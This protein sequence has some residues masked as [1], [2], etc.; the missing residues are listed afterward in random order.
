MIPECNGDLVTFI[1][2]IAAKCQNNW[3]YLCGCAGLLN[4]NK[5]HA[6]IFCKSVNSA[7]VELMC[8]QITYKL[9]IYIYLLYFFIAGNIPIDLLP[10][11]KIKP[12]NTRTHTHPALILLFCP[13]FL[14]FPRPP[15]SYSFHCIFYFCLF[16]PSSL[17]LSLCM[18][19]SMPLLMLF[20]LSV[21]QCLY[22]LACWEHSSVASSTKGQWWASSL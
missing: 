21:A 17:S 13:S 20:H 15:S 12:L 5:V 18:T 14:L 10:L 11:W 19:I 7:C 1:T 3:K 4:S 22:P 6:L 8:S 16:L 2:S 9:Y